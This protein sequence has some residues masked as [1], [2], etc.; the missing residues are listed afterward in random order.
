MDALKAS[1]LAI[2]HL[3]NKG[4]IIFKKE[5]QSI[6]LRR[7]VWYVIIVAPKFTGTI[8]VEDKSCEIWVTSIHMFNLE[9]HDIKYKT[10]GRGNDS[11]GRVNLPLS[12]ID[13]KVAVVLL[14][15]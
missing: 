8:T 10:V 2:E 5:I 1:T 9:G 11:S 15:V 12:W 6:K 7:G 3:A 13:K 4:I 14:E